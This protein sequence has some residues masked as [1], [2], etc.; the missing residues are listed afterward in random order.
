M[1]FFLVMIIN[2]CPFWSEHTVRTESLLVH[3][4]NLQP[5]GVLRIS[6]TRTTS[7][8]RDQILV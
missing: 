7:R 8:K 4:L 2:E 1:F 5:I 3:M 6:M